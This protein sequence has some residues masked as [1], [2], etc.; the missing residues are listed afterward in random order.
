MNLQNL[1]SH[2]LELKFDGSYAI[3][4]LNFFAKF[5][6]KADDLNISSTEAYLALNKFIKSPATTQYR[7]AV[8]TSTGGGRTVSTWPR[9]VDYL[10][11]ECHE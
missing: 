7:I 4:V 5:A 6:N 8:Y 1:S 3:S 10:L 11:K 9:A 2:F